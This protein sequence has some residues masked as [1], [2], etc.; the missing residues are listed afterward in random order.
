MKPQPYYAR[1][2]FLA[3]MLLVAGRYFPAQ[4]LHILLQSTG[5]GLLIWALVLLYL[6]R[7]GKS[8]WNGPNWGR[9]LRTSPKFKRVLMVVPALCAAWIPILFLLNHRWGLS[10][11]QIGFACGVLVGISF[12]ALV[13][14]KSKSE[15]CDGPIETP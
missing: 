15:N 14:M 8:N 2:S 5:I 11:G 13:K 3:F 7:T 9:K 12:V 6:R 1:L 4:P 10:D